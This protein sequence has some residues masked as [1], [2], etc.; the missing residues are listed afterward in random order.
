MAIDFFIDLGTVAGKI[1]GNVLFNGFDH[2]LTAEHKAR[3][4]GLKLAHFNRSVK[5]IQTYL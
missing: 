2:D 3:Q 5:L 1:C 4:V